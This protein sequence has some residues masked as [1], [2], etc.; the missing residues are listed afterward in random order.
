MEEKGYL[1]QLQLARLI[2][3][4]TNLN[5]FLVHGRK[6]V[7]MLEAHVYSHSDIKLPTLLEKLEQNPIAVGVP[8]RLTVGQGMTYCIIK[9]PYRENLGAR[10]IVGPFL[11][12][13]PKQLPKKRSLKKEHY[14]LPVLETIKLTDIELLMANLV[15]N[16][17]VKVEAIEVP[18]ATRTEEKSSQNYEISETD[19]LSIEARY[20]EQAKIRHAIEIGDLTTYLE[21]AEKFENYYL[22]FKDRIVGNPL[23]VAKNIAIIA[24]VSD[25]IAA[26]YGGVHPF[27]LDSISK[28]YAIEIEKC[29]TIE[30][31]NNLNHEMPLEYCKLV[32]KYS[33]KG[34]SPLVNRIIE[35]IYL[36]LAKP[37]TLAEI[38][39]HV[40]LNKTYMC[41]LFKKE[42]QTTI[43][44]FITDAKL[45]EAEYLIKEGS[46]T[47]NEIAYSLGYYDYGYFSKVFK[48][49][50]GYSPK[51]YS[52]Q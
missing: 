21:M 25:R 20:S 30:M 35:Y 10:L 7:L 22:L 50:L 32:R 36:N 37:I 38:A 6:V 33:S 31:L 40:N 51:E 43:T 24:N 5:V 8:F 2:N 29:N 12:N 17:L 26:E 15:A 14:S 34:H 44:K 23:R 1:E 46:M 27:Y 9:L 4:L 19:L 48:K 47:L 13:D 18:E 49:K 39:E 42:L 52:K 41:K 11:L 3:S 16:P 45:G 28:K